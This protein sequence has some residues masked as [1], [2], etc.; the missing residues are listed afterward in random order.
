MEVEK[1]TDLV[2]EIKKLIETSK[3]KIAVSV[4][5]EMTLLYWNIGKRVNEEIEK[6]NEEIY[7]KKIVAT[8]WLQLSKAYG[9]SFSEKNLRRMMQ[10]AKV[11]PDEKIVV[12]VIRQLSWT[13]LLA[14]IPIEDPLKRDFYIEMCKMEK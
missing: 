3:T 1:T 12:S 2:I 6:Y 5:A 10:I 7:G 9:N 11:F 8:L 14:V 4:N 13:H